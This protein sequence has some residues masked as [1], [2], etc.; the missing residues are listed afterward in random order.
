MK[1]RPSNRAGSFDRAVSADAAPADLDT[2]IIDAFLARVG[3]VD[4]SAVPGRGTSTELLTH[5]GLLVEGRPTNAAVL[6]FSRKAQRFVGSSKVICTCVPERERTQRGRR[7]TYNGTVFELVDQSVDYVMTDMTEAISRGEHEAAGIGI[8]RE[9]V[10]EAMVNAVAHRDYA[11]DRAI[12]VTLFGDRVEVWNAGVLPPSITI[13]MLRRPHESVPRNPLLARMLYLAG[14][15][16]R[17]GTGTRDMIMTCR[18]V[19][20]PVPQFTVK[21]GFVISLWWRSANQAEK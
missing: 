14:Y 8:P 13:D 20:L 19:G 7:R 3:A 2:K 12:E 10:Q 16:V 4:A 5:L 9:V 11:D 18:G 17:R 6:L 21:D 1:E 15:T